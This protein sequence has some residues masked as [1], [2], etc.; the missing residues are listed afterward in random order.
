MLLSHSIEDLIY[1]IQFTW[2][3]YGPRRQ[4]KKLISLNVHMQISFNMLSA[5]FIQPIE[6]IITK[7]NTS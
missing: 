6:S 5:V 2:F 1:P 4:K 7:L 3:V